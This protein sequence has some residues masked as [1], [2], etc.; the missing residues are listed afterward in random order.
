MSERD[1]ERRAS[2]TG[3]AIRTS[4]DTAT[5]ADQPFAAVPVLAERDLGDALAHALDE[6]TLDIL[7]STGC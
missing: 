4:G 5:T 1:I 7:A 3:S 6:E 2:K